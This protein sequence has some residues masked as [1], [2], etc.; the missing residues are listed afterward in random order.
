VS[1]HLAAEHAPE[2]ELADLGLEPASLALDVL[3][4]GF[5]VL[6]LGQL[7]QRVRIAE[8]MRGAIELLQFR[9]EP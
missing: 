1:V 7:Q 8:R 2:L 5:V 3:C 6:A 4:R 9:G